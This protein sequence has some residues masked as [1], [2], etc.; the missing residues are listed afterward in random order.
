MV[1]STKKRIEYI[2]QYEDY[3]SVLGGRLECTM[4]NIADNFLN[5]FPSRCQGNLE[6]KLDTYIVYN[7][8]RKATSSAKKKK[9]NASAALHQTPDGALLDILRN[10]YDLFTECDIKLSMIEPNDKYVDSPPPYLILLHL[11]LGPFWEVQDRNLRE[12]P[13][14]VTQ[15]CN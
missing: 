8:R 12:V 3:H 1:L 4:Q 15:N 14:P 10:A 2:Y 11:A 5:K 7:E 13:L 9:P 6:E